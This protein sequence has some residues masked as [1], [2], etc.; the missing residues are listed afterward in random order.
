MVALNLPATALSFPLLKRLAIIKSKGSTPHL[1]LQ[2]ENPWKPSLTEAPG[3]AP[4]HL[5]A[6]CEQR[7]KNRKRL[8]SHLMNYLLQWICGSVYGV[9][10]KGV[11]DSSQSYL[12]MRRMGIKPMCKTPVRRDTSRLLIRQ[13]AW[14][15][16]SQWRRQESNLHTK[17]SCSPHP[18]S[19]APMHLE[20]KPRKPPDDAGVGLPQLISL[21]STLRG[22]EKT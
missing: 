16:I 21:R 9:K 5:V 4:R 17:H 10:D 1:R 14:K 20:K 8:L 19:R 22:K 3:V 2:R 15:E 18:M 12:S 11:H 6:G 7:G 13:L